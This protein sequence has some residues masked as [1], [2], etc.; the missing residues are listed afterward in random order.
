MVRAQERTT[1]E[2]DLAADQTDIEVKLVND[3]VQFS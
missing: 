3:K 1:L 2:S